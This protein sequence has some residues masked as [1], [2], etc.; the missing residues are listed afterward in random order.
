MVLALALSKQDIRVCIAD[1]ADAPGTTSRAKAVLGLDELSMRV[2]VESCLWK[3]HW[4]LDT[5]RNC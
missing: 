3:A 4:A 5:Q 1:Q 2:S